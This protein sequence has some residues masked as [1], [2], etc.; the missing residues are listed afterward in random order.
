[1]RPHTKACG[2]ESIAATLATT[3]KLHHETERLFQISGMYDEKPHFKA[4][5]M[6]T[7]VPASGE[8]LSRSFY[9]RRNTLQVARELLG[10]LLVV[11]TNDGKRV[12]GLIVETEA[13]MGPEDKGSHAFGGRRTARTEPMFGE[14]GFTY[15]YFV[16]GIHYQLNVVS[17]IEAI[18]HAILIRAI[19][20]L[21]GVDDMRTRRGN[22]KEVDLTNGPGKL[23]KAMGIDM[24]FN[25]EDLLGDRIWIE[26]I[27]P[28]IPN[29]RIASGPRVG[30]S[31]AEE[32]VSKPWRFWIRGNRFVSKPNG[33]AAET[34]DAF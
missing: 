3:E 31:Y 4:P 17:N 27:G 9:T 18:P 28:R 5:D 22:V 26:R 30:I 16:Y 1:M 24:T 12:S 19:E 33:D 20:P 13:Y 29:S 2:Q 34:R 23:C 10:T 14:G 25:R 11:P 8:K 32:F 15:V 21:E 7:L 6:E